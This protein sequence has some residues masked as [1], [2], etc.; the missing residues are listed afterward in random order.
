MKGLG[1][2]L[3]N[4]GSSLQALK[5]FPCPSKK[6][7]REEIKVLANDNRGEYTSKDF[8]TYYANHGIQH[9]KMVQRIP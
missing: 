5:E 1:A 9:E 3:E 7:D 8:I 6:R 2:C 4:K